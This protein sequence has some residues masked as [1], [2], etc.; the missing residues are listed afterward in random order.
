MPI[1]T[2][3]KYRNVWKTIL[4]PKNDIGIF[5]STLFNT[6]GMDLPGAREVVRM[7][8]VGSAGVALTLCGRRD[9]SFWKRATRSAGKVKTF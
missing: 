4:G 3:G 6:R 2:Q 7:A 5:L 8:L 9:V 1:G